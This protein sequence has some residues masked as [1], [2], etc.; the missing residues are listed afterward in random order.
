MKPIDLSNKYL[1]ESLNCS[2]AMPSTVHTYSIITEF[3][4]QWA[5]E[6]FPKNYFKHVHVEGKHVFDD[7]RKFSVDDA[8]KKV[9]PWIAI[10]PKINLDYDRNTL[11]TNQFGADMLMKTGRIDRALIR[12]YR[13]NNFIGTSMELLEM[14]FGFKMLVESRAQQID[15][16]K[17]ISTT[18]S[19]GHTAD[20]VIDL[21]YHIPYTIMLQLASDSDF[22]VIDDKILDVVGFLNYVNSIS[23]LPILFKYRTINGRMEFFI[24]F[25]NVDI[26]LDLTESLGY[27]DGNA[28]GMLNKD[29]SVDFNIKVKAPSPKFFIYY[30]SNSHELIEGVSTVN[31]AQ[32]DLDGTIYP[33]YT[34]QL[35]TVPKIN[36]K[37]WNQYITT[38][39]F[40]DKIKEDVYVE[41]DLSG[42]F[43]S[44]TEISRIIE[45]CIDTGISPDLFIEFKIYNG[46]KHLVEYEVDWS[47]INL[48]YLEYVTA[49]TSFIAIYIDTEYVFEALNDMKSMNSQR[50]EDKTPKR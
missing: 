16:Y 33:I 3:I 1:K 15:L 17:Y 45:L 20:A 34:I 14:D 43:D 42:L 19:I 23:R 22:E 25:D 5:F 46:E 39:Y 36:D 13:R 35:D 49:H 48:K 10:V 37:G 4:K 38:E 8:I 40:D 24:R 27:D 7:F 26:L 30:S 32:N 29:Y 2:L 18:F 11:N 44:G 12:D 47:T 21:D 41:I 28:R 50:F 6:R 9:K 31:G